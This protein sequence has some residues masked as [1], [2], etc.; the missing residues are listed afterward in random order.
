MAGRSIN[1]RSINARRINARRISI[2]GQAV[3]V[4]VF[5]DQG[6]AGDALEVGTNNARARALEA[7]AARRSSDPLAPS[8]A[9]ADSGR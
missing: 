7:T 4:S 6:Y 9:F 2:V 3:V 5:G 1:A 8:S